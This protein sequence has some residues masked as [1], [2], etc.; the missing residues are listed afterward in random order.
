MRTPPLN[1]ADQVDAAMLHIAGIKQ[2]HLAAKEGNP[3][4]YSVPSAE[5]ANGVLQ[6]LT[7]A[8]SS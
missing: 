5:K 4:R 2:A 7:W 8:C 6:A 1:R 3:L